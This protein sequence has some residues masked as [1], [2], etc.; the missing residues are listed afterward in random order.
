MPIDGYY[1]LH[2]NGDLIYKRAFDGEDDFD[3]ESSG[4]VKRYWPVDMSKRGHAWTV[5]VEALALGVNAERINGLAEKWALTD[6]DAQ[7]YAEVIGVRLYK[8]GVQWCAT[9]QDFMNLQESQSG[10]GDRCIDA[11]ADFA[12]HG[13]STVSSKRC[14]L[15]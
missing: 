12:R 10:F 4:F 2:T 7:H 11:L 14:P 1:Y 6:E 5:A 8:D 9:F 3:F 13:L 15:P